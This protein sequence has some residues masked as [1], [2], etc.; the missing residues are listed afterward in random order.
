MIDKKLFHKICS[1]KPDL[2]STVPESVISQQHLEELR[3]IPQVA[4][5]EVPGYDDVSELSR[6]LSK[7]RP[8]AFVPTIVYTGTEYGAWDACYAACKKLKKKVQK[9]LNIYCTDPIIL[10]APLFWNALN[11]AF[12]NL[13]QERFQL[14]CTCLGCRIYAGAV[15]IPLC[16]ALDARLLILSST[17]PYHRCRIPLGGELFYYCRI[18][19]SGFGIE[20]MQPENTIGTSS[21]A[22][23]QTESVQEFLTCAFARDPYDQIMTKEK[24]VARPL[25][26]KKFFET[27]AIPACARVISKILSGAHVD[28][29]DE[30]KKIF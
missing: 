2:F 20:L 28:Y 22:D 25:N 27:F 16:K 4:V 1:D 15:R 7:Y 14:P 13:L 6:I 29:A 30:I 18:F 11:G 8:D 10:G 12:A 23:Q 17:G 9:T 5:G 26:M 19:L 24:S 21:D 3:S